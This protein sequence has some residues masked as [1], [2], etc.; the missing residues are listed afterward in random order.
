[1]FAAVN[2]LSWTLP[3]KVGHEERM[4]A[5]EPWGSA[6]GAQRSSEI[7]LP[8]NSGTTEA[9]GSLLTHSTCPQFSF[10]ASP[11]LTQYFSKHGDVF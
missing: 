10:D 6:L 2:L 8:S 9:W 11:F 5:T 3:G 7:R 4:A 1:M